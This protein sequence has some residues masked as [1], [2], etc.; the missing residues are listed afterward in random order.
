MTTQRKGLIFTIAAALCIGLFTTGQLFGQSQQIVVNVEAMDHAFEVDAP[1]ELPS[2]WI[3]FVLNNQMANN[4]H[5]I[6]LVQLPDEATHEEYLTDYMSAWETVLREYQES[7]VERSGISDRVNE[8][9]PAWSGDI[10]YATTRGLVSPGRIAERTV[11]LEPGKYM[12]VCW[13]KT[14]DGVI[15]I[16]E[17]MHWEFTVTEDAA[18]SPEPNPESRITL[19]ENEIEVDWEPGTGK[20]TFELES[21]RDPAGRAYHNNLHLVRME[22][23]TDLNEVNDWL[24]WYKIGGLRSPSPAEF[25]GGIGFVRTVD[26]AYFSLDIT[27]PGEY[28]WIVFISQG[29]G[30]FKTFTVE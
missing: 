4:V 20:H 11:Y 16:I 29:E 23:G 14:E 6:S 2:G 17:G 8:M 24:D 22:D 10:S 13:L 19:H 12:M 1:D 21:E 18:N 9:L 26:T 5:E 28:A 7:V 15:H 30:L 27:E 25:L 3:S